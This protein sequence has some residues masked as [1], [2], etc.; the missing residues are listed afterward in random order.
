MEE[1]I[2]S[3]VHLW[4][5]D[6]T[7]YPR[8]VGATNY[9]PMR[10]TP[11]DFFSHARPSGV[12][13][14]VLVQMSFYGF[15]NSYMLDCMRAHPGVF[16]GI[17]II[18]SH[19]PDRAEAMRRLASQGVRGFRIVPG[20]APGTWLETPE[21]RAMWRDA[22]DQRLAMCALINPSDIPRIDAMCTRFPETTVVI[23]HLARIGAGGA[24][25]DEDVSS[26]CGLARHRHVLVK[27]SAFYA[28]GAKRAPY[29]D[30]A[31]LVRR[32]FEAFGPQRLMWAS[33]CPFQVQDG[34]DYAS[35]VDFVR[36]R[37]PFLTDED[38]SWLLSRTSAAH[39][40]QTAAR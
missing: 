36:A 7:R 21:M 1:A 11:E 2:D 8:L 32:V 28:L 33:D 10:F 24:V 27:V 38:R 14:A 30:L 23:D 40:F 37:L 34:H 16:A 5:D 15:D 3:H 13:R 4:T 9:P 26:L 12:T 29:S 25:R 19:A 22:A 31:P 6:R 18:D 39:F 35:S 17:A 20:S